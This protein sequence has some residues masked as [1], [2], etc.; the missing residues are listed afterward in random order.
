MF[1]LGLKHFNP[2]QAQLT[3]ASDLM[4]PYLKPNVQTLKE[5]RKRKIKAIQ[6]MKSLNICQTKVTVEQVQISV[7]DDEKF[8]KMDSDVKMGK[9]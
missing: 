8:L 1:Y 9:W 4:I 2:C 5:L 7:S 3:L 6:N